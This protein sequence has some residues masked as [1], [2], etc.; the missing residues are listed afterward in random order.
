[1]RHGGGLALIVTV[2]TLLS[3]P[4][5]HAQL[6]FL[7]PGPGVFYLG[8]EGGWT[9]LASEFAKARIPG[10]GLWADG[11]RYHDGFNAGARLGFDWE[12]WRIEEEFRYQSN[13]A[14]WMG[15][16]PFRPV[17][18]GGYTRAGRIF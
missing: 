9:S 10:I 5:A 1:M 2:L 12:P 6:Q 13:S 17:S 3:A 14:Q 18:R 11:L 8:G 15:V 7:T 4:A 16:W